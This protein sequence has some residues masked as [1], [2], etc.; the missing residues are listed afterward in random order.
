MNERTLGSVRASTYD[1]RRLFD[2]DVTPTPLTSM[3]DVNWEHQAAAIKA[4]CKSVADM[5]IDELL[6][7]VGKLEARVAAL[8]GGGVVVQEEDG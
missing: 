3:K 8:E 1:R 7:Q 5:A 2:R 4:G 6:D